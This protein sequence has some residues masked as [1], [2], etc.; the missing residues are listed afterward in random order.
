M[1]NLNELGIISEVSGARARVAIGSMVTD[2]LPVIQMGENS[3]KT[4]WEPLRVGEQCIVLPIR[5]ELNS[6]IVIRGAETLSY[7]VPSIDENIEIIKFNDGMF[8]K[9][10]NFKR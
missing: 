4:T 2:F 6:G 10:D 8:V 5:G 1:T 9:Y 3:F 7:P